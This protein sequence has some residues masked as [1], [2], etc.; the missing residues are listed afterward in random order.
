MARDLSY[1]VIVRWAT[2]AIGVAMAL[3]HMWAI[4]FGTPEAIIFRGTHLAFAVTLTF[5]VTRWSETTNDEPPSL[6]DYAL[7]VFAVTPILYLFV[8]YDYIVNRIYYIDDLTWS[9][10]TLGTILVV[11]VLAETRRLIGWALPITAL[12]F[13][14]YALLYMR[15]EP[16][17]LILAVMYS[18]YSAPLAALAGTLSIFPVAALRASPRRTVTIRK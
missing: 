17:R 6:L 18:G 15:I 14:A 16:M 2:G 11:L 5:L 13:L 8:N 1:G 9:D 7:L 10:M 4:A 3:Y 12:V